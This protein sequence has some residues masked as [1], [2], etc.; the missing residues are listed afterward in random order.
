MNDDDMEKLLKQLTRIAESLETLAGCVNRD[1][2]FVVKA[3]TD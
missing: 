2:N 3:Y 1:G